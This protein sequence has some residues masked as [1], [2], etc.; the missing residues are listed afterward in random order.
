MAAGKLLLD[1]REY[2]VSEVVP[3]PKISVT[4]LIRSKASRV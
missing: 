4:V 1:V 3:V 2:S